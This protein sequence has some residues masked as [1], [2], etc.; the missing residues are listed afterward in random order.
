MRT[1]RP[2][3]ALNAV[4]QWLENPVNQDK[5]DAIVFCTFL[6]QEFA[7]YSE[8]IPYYFPPPAAAGAVKVAE[9]APTKSETGDPGRQLGPGRGQDAEAR[10]SEEELRGSDEFPAEADNAKQEI[11]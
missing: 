4:R 3:V 9:N 1:D 11:Y 10:L 6:D 8:L 7:A 5:V 2:A